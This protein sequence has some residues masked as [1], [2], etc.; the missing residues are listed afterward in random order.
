[1]QRYWFLTGL[2]LFDVISSR[3]MEGI[4]FFSFRYSSDDWIFLPGDYTEKVALIEE[5]S[6]KISRI[7]ATD[8]EE[9]KALLNPGDVFGIRF[10]K[11]NRHEGVI[12]AENGSPLDP[13]GTS[14]GYKVKE[15][16]SERVE[17]AKALSRT[18]IKVYSLYDF[19]NIIREERKIFSKYKKARN[20]F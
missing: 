11:K 4:P 13:G 3:S 1:M 2:N 7:T 12:P 8:S 9:I 18:T 5:G 19:E 10:A 16:L 17:V 20:I 6:V 14:R 15:P